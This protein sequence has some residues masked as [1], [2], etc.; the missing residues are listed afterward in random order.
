MQQENENLV[1]ALNLNFKNSEESQIDQRSSLEKKNS[2]SQLDSKETFILINHKNESNDL[3]MPSLNRVDTVES[4]QIMQL[5][6]IEEEPQMTFQNSRE[7][8]NVKEDKTADIVKSRMRSQKL[9]LTIDDV[10]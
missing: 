2:L 10:N 4:K 3:S 9:P 6:K 8:L 1:S 7:S 5:T